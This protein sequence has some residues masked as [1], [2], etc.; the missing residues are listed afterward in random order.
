MQT[1][2]PTERVVRFKDLELNLYTRELCKHGLKCRLQGHPIDVL[3]MLLAH[4]GEL[5]TREELRKKLWPEDTF[6]DFEHGLNSTINRLREALGDHAESPRYIETLP[7]LGYRLIAEE[8]PT[9]SEVTDAVMAEENPYA[10]HA[11]YAS[12]E[13]CAEAEEFP[14]AVI[15]L[16]RR[17]A[18]WIFWIVA[19]A[20]AL[21][22][23]AFAIH[24]FGMP[25][26][27]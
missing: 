15:T 6:V 19:L 4:P 22:A 7:R 9:Q 3:E 18:F 16:Q 10:A 25:S 8:E 2:A 23:V 1:S 14:P 17:L 24:V 20:M 5:V 26:H 12:L 21:L 27:P 11:P 13:D